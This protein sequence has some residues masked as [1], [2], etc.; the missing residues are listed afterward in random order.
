M[1]EA[2]HCPTADPSGPPGP[3]GPPGQLTGPVSS[4]VCHLDLH[5]LHVNSSP[6]L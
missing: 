1:V 6:Y 5:Y 2:I 3:P 4:K